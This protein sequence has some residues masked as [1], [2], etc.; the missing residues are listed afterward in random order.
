MIYGGGFVDFWVLQA[1]SGP[2]T[3]I[4]NRLQ[5]FGEFEIVLF[6]DRVILGD[7]I[8]TWP[9]CDCLIAF[10][11]SGYPLAKVEAYAD[12]RKFVFFSSLSLSLSLSLF[13]SFSFPPSLPS[14]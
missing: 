9:I 1:L 14:K 6:G 11:S 8:E 13:F 3:Q 12:L 7:P 4:L 5:Q 2:M 10:S